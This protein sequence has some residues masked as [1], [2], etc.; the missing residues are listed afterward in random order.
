MHSPRTGKM[1]ESNECQMMS[2]QFLLGRSNVKM[3]S[4]SWGQLHISWYRGVFLSENKNAFSDRTS[5]NTHS[6]YS[7]MYSPLIHV[8]TGK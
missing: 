4:L 2:E 3:S 6:D 5:T 7:Y 1:L 8:I